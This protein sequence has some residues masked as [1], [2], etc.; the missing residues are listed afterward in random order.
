MTREGRSQKNTHF[1]RINITNRD[2]YSTLKIIVRKKT[3][4]KSFQ[5]S[6]KIGDDMKKKKKKKCYDGTLTETSFK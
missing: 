6:D 3:T 4:E 5:T 2:F 1:V